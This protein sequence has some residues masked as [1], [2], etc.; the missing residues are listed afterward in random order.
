MARGLVDAPPQLIDGFD[1]SDFGRDQTQDGNLAFRH[2]TQRFETTGTLGVVLQQ[3][4]LV[5]QSAE[6]FFGDGV[7]VRF[8]MPHAPSVAAADVHPKNSARTASNDL[9]LCINR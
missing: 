7:I 8:P 2:E 3:E 4:T 5:I 9:V 6:E 1:S